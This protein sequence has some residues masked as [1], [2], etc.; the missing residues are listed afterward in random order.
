MI[1]FLYQSM[2]NTSNTCLFM[3]VG[4]NVEFVDSAASL[5][6]NYDFLQNSTISELN[7][8]KLEK[9]CF[10]NNVG[11]FLI[12]RTRTSNT[13][14]VINNTYINVFNMLTQLKRLELPSL[15]HIASDIVFSA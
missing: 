15:T 2:T 11:Q 1:T 6:I 8:Q 4:A 3:T 14:T 7:V 5:H 13:A 10:N 12:F 9:I